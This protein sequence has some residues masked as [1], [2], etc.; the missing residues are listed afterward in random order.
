[1]F[2]DQAGQPLPVGT[3]VKNPALAATLETL[4]RDG[5]DAFYSGANASAIGAMVSAATPQNR[6]GSKKILIVSFLL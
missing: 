5:A 2:F 4:A 3:M 6:C 1:M